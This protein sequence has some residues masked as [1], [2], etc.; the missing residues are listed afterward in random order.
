MNYYNKN[1][2]EKKRK[3]KRKKRLNIKTSAATITI[4]A[5]AG[6]LATKALRPAPNN[7]LHIP[8]NPARRVI[9]ERLH[10]RF[11]RERLKMR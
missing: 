10:V 1:K 2:I 11:L 9:L 5:P 8:N 7:P 6:N 3:E 4:K